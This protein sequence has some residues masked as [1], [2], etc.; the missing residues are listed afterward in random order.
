M[1]CGHFYAFA[2]IVDAQY[3]HSFVGEVMFKVRFTPFPASKL[4]ET[5]KWLRDRAGDSIP[6]FSTGPGFRDCG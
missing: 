5:K 3:G 6:D 4:T 1:H 2:A